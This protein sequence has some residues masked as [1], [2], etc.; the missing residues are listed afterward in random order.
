MD[1]DLTVPPGAYNNN[2]IL[3]T[4]SLDEPTHR[5]LHH[6]EQSYKG[7][8]QELFDPADLDALHSSFD[9][10][11]LNIER[12]RPHDAASACNATSSWDENDPG[13]ADGSE[14]TH[15]RTY[16]SIEI[17]ELPPPRSV[18]KSSRIAN[19][20]PGLSKTPLRLRFRPP[21]TAVK[22]VVGKLTPAS[23]KRHRAPLQRRSPMR[24]VPPK[25]PRDLSS[26]LTP[27]TAKQLPE[28]S[29]ARASHTAGGFG[30]F[31]P[32]CLDG[33]DLYGATPSGFSSK[34][35]PKT[36][37]GTVATVA[38]STLLET[39]TET[40][41]SV[42]TSDTSGALFRF[43]SFPA[44]LPRINNVG[45]VERQCPG[46]VERQCPGTVRKRMF[47]DPLNTSRN[48]DDGTHNSSMSSLQDDVQYAYSDDEEDDETGPSPIGTPV[49]RTRLN[50]NTVLSPLGAYMGRLE[51]QAE[52]TLVFALQHERS[53]VVCLFTHSLHCFFVYRSIGSMQI[54]ADKIDLSRPYEQKRAS[55]FAS[56]LSS[57]TNKNFSLF[58]DTYT[59]STSGLTP[60]RGGGPSETRLE[61]HHLGSPKVQLHLQLDTAL[62]SPIRGI[63]EE[64]G[65]VSSK[66]S[67]NK[68]AMPDFRRATSYDSV[69]SSTSSKKRRPLPMPDMHAFDGG[70]LS[71]SVDDSATT[72]TRS[73]PP[74]PKLLCPP[75]PVRTP[76]WVHSDAAG[77]TFFKA[78]AGNSKFHRA[79]SLIATKVLATCSPQVLDGRTSLENSVLEEEGS[80]TSAKPHA[81]SCG[82]TQG[83][84][85][86]V[87]TI[88]ANES[89]P[90]EDDDSW[91]HDA[92]TSESHRPLPQPNLEPR[93][94]TGEI[95]SMETNFETLSL[96]GSGTFADVY[97]V[98]SKVDQ[99]LYAVKR[100]RRQFRG[101]RDRDQAL[102]EVR[103][104]Q[105]LQSVCV[106]TVDAKEDKEK[107]SYSLYLLF[108]YQAWQEEG[109]FFCQTEL[110]CRDTCRELM[111]SLRSH[112]MVAKTRYPCIRQ[113]P[114]L[115]SITAGSEADAAGRLVPEQTIWKICHD[116]SAGLSH[117][118]SHGL[119]H[120]DIKP[121]NVFFVPHG[122]FGAMCKIGDFGMA[123][124]IGS[125]ADGQEGDQMYMAPEL[126]SSGVKHPSA[127]TFSLGLMLYEL[128]SDLS[129]E[130][131]TEGPRWHELRSGQH[132]PRI[133][134]SRSSD[135]L[136]L[137]RLLLSP[138]GERRPTAETILLN[139]TVISAGSERDEFLRDYIRGID[140]F[141]LREQE[142]E[143][144]DKREEQTPHGHSRMR[145]CSPSM[146][147]L[148]PIPPMLYSPEA[149]K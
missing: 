113:L 16:H 70:A 64:S 115:D 31:L 135:L 90:M 141:D 48:D 21:G 96:L 81:A 136:Q 15:L 86:D 18:R 100:N 6:T 5:A 129:F 91:L 140:D 32:T 121:S 123:G 74:S 28:N 102:G 34:K 131:P 106:A 35:P 36:S 67:G 95:V 120:Y 12:E 33:F 61:S 14:Q 119:V 143:G 72:G 126:L 23:A 13:F 105:R 87:D 51:N 10:S 124:D 11:L 17:P 3:R 50:F 2:M 68:N 93:R 149:A 110:C 80:N 104:M 116:L 42:D 52:G 56:S 62:C 73:H 27:R 83:G 26:S 76:A 53:A 122:R 7:S 117:I 39:T 109:H 130:V 137:V 111:D 4:R 139:D 145:V 92:R 63:P 44:S 29:I 9:S 89:S 30:S 147:H 24:R 60:S 112:W 46:M 38:S 114:L 69:S 132:S 127:D 108:F 94:S 66:S 118:H 125:S 75:T 133:P 37:F 142:R 55:S 1:L 57:H 45:T 20:E 58:D 71:S 88:I 54:D 65:E 47:G 85:S 146:G 25:T 49:A 97:K 99:R 101:K 8:S 22:K 79:N 128:A 148:P 98:R 82:S 144:L 41:D 59:A 43:T 84:E 19:G 107:S 78:G 77:Q 103:H 40:A 138:A 134:S